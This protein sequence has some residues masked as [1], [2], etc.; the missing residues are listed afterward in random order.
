MRAPLSILSL[1]SLCLL[2][3][4]SQRTYYDA[5][6]NPIDAPDDKP[7]SSSLEER[8]TSSF[9]M[10]KNKDGVPMA[11]SKKVSGFQEKINNAREGGNES[12]ERKSY[13]GV[14]AFT[15]AE[16]RSDWRSKTVE[17]KRYQSDA[18]SPYSREMTPDFLKDGRGL[19]ARKDA[20]LSSSRSRYDG[21][22][23]TSDT[24]TMGSQEAT[25][26]PY[27]T[28]DRSGYFVKQQDQAQAPKIIH[29]DDYIR[30]T[31]EESRA[32]LGRDEDE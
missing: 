4:E 5:A 17:K 11:V 28:S 8:F 16:S 9:T 14:H 25:R 27:S 31:I 26:S 19:V 13:D 2:S 3:C 7:K 10:K 20:N 12:I 21:F 32:M 6:G 1:A 15:G 30:M 29:R 24:D 23:S 18:Q 22:V